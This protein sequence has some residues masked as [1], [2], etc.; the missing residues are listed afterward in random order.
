MA[1][2]R[3]TPYGCFNFL[4]SFDGL[5]PESVQAGFSGVHGLDLSVEVLQYR[6]GNDKSNAPRLVAG[7]RKPVTVTLTRGVIG[8]L[9][10][11]EWLDTSQ[12]G[13][14]DRRTVT[15]KLLSEDRGDT[16]QLWKLVDAWP[17]ALEGPVLDA[18][19]S[20]VAIERLV[21]VAETMS[22]E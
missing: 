10:L 17:T 4:V 7:R 9:T 1:V 3:D 14:P 5:D 21:L 15:I 20:S 8:D 19:G 13:S 2:L 12:H 6:A 22:I 18:L 16:V 11:Y